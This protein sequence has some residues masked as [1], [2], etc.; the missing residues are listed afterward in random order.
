MS[1]PTLATDMS[2]QNPD[3]EM[4]KSVCA[5]GR[6][7]DAFWPVNQ[8]KSSPIALLLCS[9]QIVILFVH[10]SQTGLKLN[11]QRSKS[12]GSKT[13]IIQ[14]YLNL[15]QGY[16]LHFFFCCHKYPRLQDYRIHRPQTVCHLSRRKIQG[17][18]QRYLNPRTDPG[19]LS[20]D[21]RF[22][23][24]IHKGWSKIKS[25]V[26]GEFFPQRFS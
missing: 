2:V 12:P 13:L 8:N 14:R 15:K 10:D 3:H 25:F 5:S 18:D 21:P 22:P 23:F 19:F 16:T 20:R 4:R 26:V 6:L 7:H 17:L 11:S 9:L 24:A 1:F